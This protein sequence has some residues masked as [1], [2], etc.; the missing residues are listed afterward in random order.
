MLLSDIVTTSTAVAATRSRLAK[1]RALAGLLAQAGPGEVGPAVAFLSGTPRQGRTG[2]GYRT[3]YDL[4]TSPAAAPSLTVEQTDG[5]LEEL[6]TT[7]G[8]GSAQRRAELLTGLFSA[9]TGP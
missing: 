5:V 4:T 1:V 8:K 6:S 3:L 9:A 7:A 2:T